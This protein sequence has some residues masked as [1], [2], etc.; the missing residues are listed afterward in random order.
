MIQTSPPYSY[1]AANNHSHRRYFVI[2][3]QQYC[4]EVNLYERY[5]Y[6]SFFQGQAKRLVLALK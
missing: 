5:H 3:I 6:R 4:A 2:A 1:L